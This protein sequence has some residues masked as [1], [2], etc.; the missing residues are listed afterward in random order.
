MSSRTKEVVTIGMSSAI[1]VAL[2]VALSPF[3]NIELVT[4]LFI[5]YSLT[6]P[7][8][9]VVATA[10]VFT[11]VQ[12]LVWGVG[13]WVIGYYWIWNLWVLLVVLLKPK[14]GRD[15]Y[16]WAL[17][18]GFWGLIFGA[19]FALNHGIFYGFNFSIAYWLRGIPFDLVHSISN[20]LITLIT[21]PPLMRVAETLRKEN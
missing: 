5:F 1:I 4:T 2:Q 12:A 10:S 20:Y 11:T 8:R 9:T 7:A 15:Y 21:L 19:L 18:S 3:P 6:L 14:I 16:K 13:D 17:L